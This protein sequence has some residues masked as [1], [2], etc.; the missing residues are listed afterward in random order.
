V[1]I[2]LVTGPTGSGKSTTLYSVLNILNHEG[3]NIV[4][5]E[6][7]VEYFVEGVNQSQIRPEIG[8]TFANGLRSLVRQ[9]PDIIMVGEIRD[10]ETASLAINAALTG[11]LVLST[12]HTNSAAGAM[13]RL[14]DMKIEPF[15]IV[16]TIKVII[17]QRLI[18]KL[19]GNKEKYFLSK[20]EIAALAKITDIDRVIGFLKKEK[21][22]GEKDTI[23][24]IPFYRAKQKVEAKDDYSGRVCINEVLKMNSTIKDMVIS[25]ASDTAIN[26]QAKKEGMLS[27]VEDGIFK[28]VEGVTTIEE[29][30]RVI[31]E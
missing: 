28:A 14:I 27:M 12:L 25:G 29:V 2:I 3:V 17:A 8:F 5:L 16:S 22:I 31:S 9:D 26:E 6:D 10:N 7:P 21:M 23:E 20:S 4:T 13:P 1:G 24:T 11:H 19:G 18:R 30:L 15:L